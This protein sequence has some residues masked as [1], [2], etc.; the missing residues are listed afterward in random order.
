ME[1][2]NLNY[3]KQKLNE[4][5]IDICITNNIDMQLMYNISHI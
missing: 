4:Y 5:Q 2:C 3:S 1:I